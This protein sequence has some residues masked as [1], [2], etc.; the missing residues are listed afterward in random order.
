MDSITLV[1]DDPGILRILSDK[2]NF[3]FFRKFKKTVNRTA[4]NDAISTLCFEATESGKQ[5]EC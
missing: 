4:I 3:T 1:I 5:V 2:Q